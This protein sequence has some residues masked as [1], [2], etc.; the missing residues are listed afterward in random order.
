MDVKCIIVALGI[1][2]T[3]YLLVSVMLYGMTDSLMFVV[4]FIVWGL[5]IIVELLDRIKV[6]RLVEG[7]CDSCCCRSLYRTQAHVVSLIRV[8]Y[9][10]LVSYDGDQ[11]RRGFR[12]V[13]IK[14][15]QTVSRRIEL[16]S[17]PVPTHTVILRNFIV[18]F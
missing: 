9:I 4:L 6:V 2:F 16:W 14:G 10:G 5:Y 12:S 11:R 17:M 7:N 1:C 8:S 18:I 13:K 15:L 3:I